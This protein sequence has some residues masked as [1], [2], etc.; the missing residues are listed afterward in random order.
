MARGNLSQ[1]VPRNPAKYVGPVPITLRS[2][3]EVRMAQFCDLNDQVIEWAWESQKIPYSDPLTGKQKIYI[4]DLL[5]LFVNEQ[6]IRE[7]VLV[8]VKPAHEALEERARSS[9]DRMLLARNQAKWAAAAWW[10]QRRGIKFKVMTE[11]EIFGGRMSTGGKE[12]G[13][14]TVRLTKSKAKSGAKRPK[15]KAQSGTRKLNNTRPPSRPKRPTRPA[16]PPRR[17]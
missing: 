10:C 15:S 5:L 17:S 4:P 7:S 1:Y 12:V 14:K 11:D 8:E 13:A 3:W 9:G 6:G 16:P 2:S